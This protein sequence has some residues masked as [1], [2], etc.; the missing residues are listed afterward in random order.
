MKKYIFS[1]LVA[2]LCFAFIVPAFADLS[3]GCRD[4]QLGS[5]SSGFGSNTVDTSLSYEALNS[6]VLILILVFNPGLSLFLLAC[7]LVL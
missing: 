1:F 7:F 6:C 3:G 2:C 5:F 4:S